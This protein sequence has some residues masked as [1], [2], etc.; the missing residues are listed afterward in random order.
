MSYE[1]VP[2]E[3][4]SYPQWVAYRAVPKAAGKVDKIPVDPKTGRNAKADKPE[5]W[6]TFDEACQAVSKYGLAGIGF[7]FSKSD[8]FVGIDLDGCRDAETKAIEPWAQRWIDHF[9]SY[10]EV[11]PSGKG[12]H[13]IIKGQLP[14]GGNRK[15]AI[16]VYDSGRFFTVTGGAI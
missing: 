2:E 12:V 6:G 4:K 15:G 16:E 3:L 13:I 5:T 8:P 10:T 14:A 9:K 1:S 11:S 7:E